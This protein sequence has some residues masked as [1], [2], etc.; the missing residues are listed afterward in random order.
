MAFLGQT[1]SH[2]AFDT[3]VYCGI[4]EE[5]SRG[6]QTIT[7]IALLAI[8]TAPTTHKIIPNTPVVLSESQ[9]MAAFQVA[10]YHLTLSRQNAG[11][12]DYVI[13]GHPL[14]IWNR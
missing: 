12:T 1:I 10:I 2:L 14:G 8:S 3:K 9:R 6:D 4:T 11:R 7:F 5:N 13:L